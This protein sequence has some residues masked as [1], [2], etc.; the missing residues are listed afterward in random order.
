MA[1]HFHLLDL[2]DKHFPYTKGWMDVSE[3][4]L[5]AN[6]ALLKEFVE[7]EEPFR[8]HFRKDGQIPA[9]KKGQ[10]VG[11]YAALKRQRKTGLEIWQLYCWWTKTRKVEHA[12]LKKLLMTVYRGSKKSKKQLSPLLGK[13]SK[14][15][16][17]WRMEE[18]L[19]DKDQE[20]LH[21]LIEVRECLWT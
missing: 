2:R 3:K 6:F 16:T 8:F 12:V 20:M 13:H 7:K 1:R 4:V 14:W 21:R 18:R 19:E 10:D 11:E 9:R 15:K 17:Y 5:L